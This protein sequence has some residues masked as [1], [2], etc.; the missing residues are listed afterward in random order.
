MMFALMRQDWIKCQLTQVNKD[1]G[2][3][4][5][6]LL[7]HFNVKCDNELSPNAIQET[8]TIEAA[9]KTVH[10]LV[11]A[12]IALIA[13][14]MSMKLLAPPLKVNNWCNW[15][16]TSDVVQ[17]DMDREF[18]AMFPLPDQPLQEQ[19]L[20]MPPFHRMAPQRGLC[21]TTTGCMSTQP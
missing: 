12:T 20:T 21:I 15:V 13:S 10:E 2:A 8:I 17:Q 5:N 18:Q 9:A 6:V 3:D 14:T 16:T 11:V 19:P 1:A 7:N 4:A